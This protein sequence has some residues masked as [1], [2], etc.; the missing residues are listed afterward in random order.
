MNIYQDIILDHYHHPHNQGR[1][2]ISGKSVQVSN[3][4]C[5]DKI[6]MTIVFE[7]NKVKEVKFQGE[8]CVISTASASMLTDYAKNK[9]KQEL[10]KLDSK[11]IIKMLGIDLGMTRIKCALLPLE[12]LHK[13]L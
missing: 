12:A 5:G 11:F 7:K 8:G 9:S 4:L 13:L 6:E 1:L 2:D 10:K 3:P